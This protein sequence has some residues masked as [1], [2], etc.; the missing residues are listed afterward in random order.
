MTIRLLPALLAVAF[1]VIPALAMAQTPAPSPA[2]AVPAVPAAPAA[3]A[4]PAVADPKIEALAKTLL[5]QAQT[6]TLART[7]VTDEMSAQ[8]TPDATKSIATK[9]GPLGDYTSFTYGG[10]QTQPDGLII[11][12]FVVGFKDTVLDEYIGMTPDGKIAGLK[13]AKHVAP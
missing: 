11:Y 8:M 9:M 13:F 3:P 10:S 4:T 6:D 7:N 5:H 1:A 2:A 12:T